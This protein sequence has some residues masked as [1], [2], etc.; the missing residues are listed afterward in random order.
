MAHSLSS[1]KRVRQNAKRRMR[2]RARVGAVRTQIR[3]YVELVSQTDDIAVA[4][5]ELQL[6]QKKIDKLAAK[7]TMHKNTASRRKA[8]LARKLNELKAKQAS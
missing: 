8:Q 1:K 4:E 7:G 3:K 6:T 2:N 5:K